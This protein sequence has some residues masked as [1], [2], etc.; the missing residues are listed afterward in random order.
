MYA[1]K[2]VNLL[3]KNTEHYTPCPYGHSQAYYTMRSEIAD[4]EA[5]D[6]HEGEDYTIEVVEVDDDF[7]FENQPDWN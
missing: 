6:W 3:N 4:M 7:D 1:V 5:N 2:S